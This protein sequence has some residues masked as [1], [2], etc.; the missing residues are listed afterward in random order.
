MVQD[1]DT[2]KHWSYAQIHRNYELGET[3]GLFEISIFT[4]AYYFNKIYVR[5]FNSYIWSDVTLTGHVA[6]VQF[7]PQPE[8]PPNFAPLLEGDL[9]SF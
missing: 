7:Y 2:T 9:T 3:S 1:N 6:E 8:G 4:K 5:I